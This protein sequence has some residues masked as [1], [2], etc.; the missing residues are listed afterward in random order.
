MEMHTKTVAILAELIFYYTKIITK[1]IICVVI[2]QVT[3][4]PSPYHSP[5]LASL[6][7]PFLSNYYSHE[8]KVYT[9]EPE[10]P[11]LQQRHGTH[12]SK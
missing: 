8:L 9:S 2:Q 3:H 11:Y 7:L 5:R 10:I 12:K 1:K 6:P 4:F